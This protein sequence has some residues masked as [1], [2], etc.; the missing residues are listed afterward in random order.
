MKKIARL[1]SLLLMA[2]FL[3]AACGKKYADSGF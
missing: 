3:L 2:V 1:T